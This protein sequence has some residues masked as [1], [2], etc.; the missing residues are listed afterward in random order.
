[1]AG[2]AAGS[3]GAKTAGRRRRCWRET[4]NSNPWRALAVALVAAI[5][6]TGFARRAG[7]CSIQG[8]DSG[9]CAAPQDVQDRMPFCATVVRYPACVPTEVPWHGNLTLEAKDAWLHTSFDAFVSERRAIETGSYEPT[10][11]SACPSR[12]YGVARTHAHC[13]PPTHPQQPPTPPLQ[14]NTTTTAA[15][16]S[17]RGS[18]TTTASMRTA[19][20]CA[21]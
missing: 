18:R 15:A 3:S 7:A 12:C 14:R 1:M 9:T 17:S 16:A 2:A 19:T 20:S 6:A 21:T 13:N 5:G 4:A 11:P 10:D 8:Y